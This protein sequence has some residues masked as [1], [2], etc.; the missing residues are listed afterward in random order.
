MPIMNG[1]QATKKILALYEQKRKEN[2]TFQPP[3]IVALTANDTKEE[4]DRC[5]QSGMTVFLSK[6][7]DPAELDRVL[8]KIFGEDR[9]NLN[10]R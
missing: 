1:L 10:K 2:E 6:P 8:L 9:L 7:P 4:R 3:I 5:A